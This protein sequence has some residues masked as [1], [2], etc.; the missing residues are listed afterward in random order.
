MS[1][2]QN[3]EANSITERD[4]L[5]SK[6][7]K[8]KKS[9]RVFDRSPSLESSLSSQEGLTDLIKQKL[10]NTKKKNKQ[11]QQQQQ[12]IEVGKNNDEKKRVPKP[13]RIA[14]LASA[15][16][17]SSTRSDTDETIKSQET[18][19]ANAEEEFIFL[20]LMGKNMILWMH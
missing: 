17:R 16:R 5:Y 4:L 7:S 15:L 12:D 3:D 14:S 13:K 2:L 10:L 20:F 1:K 6:S 8:S 9:L 19:W 18:F 11:Q